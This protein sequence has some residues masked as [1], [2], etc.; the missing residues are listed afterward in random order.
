MS[1]SLGGLVAAQT[2]VHGDQRSND[3]AA[4]R[5]ARNIRGMIFLGTPFK[6]SAVAKL[7]EIARKILELFGADTQ[8]QTLKLL[9]VDSERLDELTRAFASVLG[10]RRSS[11]EPSDRLE[12][13]FLY[14]TLKTGLGKAS[15]QVL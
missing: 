1:H 2:L 8:Q 12:A 4:E 3:S 10:K 9:G 5:I 7:A 14:E 11:K 6:G 13:F 15:I